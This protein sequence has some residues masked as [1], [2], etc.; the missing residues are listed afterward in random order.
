M[1]LAIVQV[2]QIAYQLLFA[3]SFLHSCG[4][5]HTDLKPENILFRDI[6]SSFLKKRSGKL[7]LDG[8]QI[9]LIDFGNAVFSGDGSEISTAHYRA[10]EVIL[11]E[12]LEPILGWAEDRTFSPKGSVTISVLTTFASF[13]QC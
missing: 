13:V 5:I 11:G 3:V 4:I 1:I 10:P 2:R 9:R 6:S 12:L 7:D 8:R